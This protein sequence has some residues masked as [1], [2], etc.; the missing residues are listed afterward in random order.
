MRILTWNIN[1]LRAVLTKANQSLDEFIAACD[2]DIVCFQETKLTRSEMTEAFACPTSFDAFYAFSRV[3]KG[4]AGVVTF[5]RASAVHTMDA[6]TTACVFQEGRIVLT[7]H[8]E[9][10]IVNAY[11]P[12]TAGNMERKMQFLG[13]LST[14]LDTWRQDYPDKPLIFVGDFNVIHQPIDH[15]QEHIPN[16]ATVWLDSV[17]GTDNPSNQHELVDVFRHFHPNDERAYTCW[18]QLTGGRE[19]NYGVR[20]DYILLDK[21]LVDAAVDCWLWVDKVGSDHCP[22]VLDIDTLASAGAPTTASACAKFYPEFAGIQQSLHGFLSHLPPPIHTPDVPTPPPTKPSSLRQQSIA[23]Y[24]GTPKVTPTPPA[25]YPSDSTMRHSLACSVYSMS[26]A[27]M[28]TN[29]PIGGACGSESITHLDEFQTVAASWKT[30]LPGKAPPPP[31]CSGHNLPCLLR[32]VLKQNENWGRKFYLCCKPE[33]A[34]GDPNGRC[35]FFQWV[36]SKKRKAG[37]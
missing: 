19:T 4:Y 25:T 23:A 1:G 34:P 9:W 3:K 8:P 22:V 24:F 5:V 36:P 2:A 12:T 33:G 29:D 15:S 14:Q 6:D 26:P 28:S 18:S 10:M 13:S 11:C 27:S 31:L 20:L 21:R 7:V 37:A 17:L 30:L 32:T 35:D 16:E